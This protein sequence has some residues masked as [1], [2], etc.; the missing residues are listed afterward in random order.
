MRKIEIEIGLRKYSPH[1]T[2]SLPRQAVSIILALR[3]SDKTITRHI[4]IDSQR[5]IK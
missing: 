5:P 2:L 4:T 1:N 3:V